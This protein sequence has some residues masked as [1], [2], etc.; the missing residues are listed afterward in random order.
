M[1]NQGNEREIVLDMLLQVVDGEEF[2]HKVLDGVLKRNRSRTK[3]ER[4]FISRLFTGTVKRCITL[5]YIIEQFSTLPVGKMKPQIR[6]LL[7][8][9]AYQLLFM[10]GIPSFAVCNEA[11]KIAKKRGFASL[12]G[13][14]NANLRKI[15][16]MKEIKY[17]D[18][19]ADIRAYLGIRYS[20]PAWLAGMLLDQYGPEQAEMILE[21]SLKEKEVAVRCN[22]LKTTPDELKRELAGEGITV[23]EHPYLEEA[24]VIKDFDRLEDIKAFREGL[25]VVQDV[26][27]MLV[28]EAAGVREGDF[29]VDVCAAPGGKA[30]HAAQKAAKVS[31][32]DL[33]AGKIR[34]I[35]EN[36]H[37]MGISNIETKVWDATVTD[38]EIINKADV[39]IADLPCSGLG[40]IG[41][42]PDIK[43]KMTQNQQKELVE[44]QRKILSVASDYVKPGGIL[45]YSTCTINREE[46]IENMEW[47]LANHDFE[48]DSMDNYLPNTLH[49]DT[50][51]AGY[52]QLL[53]GIN[54]TDGFFISRMR[55]RKQ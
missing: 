35:E 55:K 40:V 19:E 27:S 3:Q 49:S 39:V 14:V 5:D 23:C 47:F 52:L 21:A 31:A 33:T 53:Q 15:A 28:A 16:A 48:P 34:L 43:Y 42:K 36:M 38:E 25:F 2:S 17:P 29:V 22:R 18:K 45:V 26:G 11:V 12:S 9:S 50:T 4:V 1:T 8:M 37:R 7:R 10:D 51:K 54:P 46:N 6:N 13:F 32:R 41:K 20:A 24:F 44:L 30:L